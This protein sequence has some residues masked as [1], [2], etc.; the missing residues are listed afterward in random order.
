[1][2]V[3]VRTARHDELDAVAALTERGF[4]AGP[5][6]PTTDPDRLR[7]LRDAAGRAAAGDLLVAVRGRAAA[8]HA[9]PA[10]GRHGLH[11]PGAGRRGRGAAAHHRPRRARARRRRGARR[12]VDHPR[13]RL[14]R[15]GA[16]ARHRTAQR[17]VA[18]AVPPPGVRAGGRARDRRRAPGCGPPGRV[19]LR[20][21]PHRPAGAARR[22]A[23]ARP[24]RAAVRRRLRARLRPSRRL[25]RLAGGRRDPST[26]AR[27]VGRRGPRHGRAARHRRDP[28]TRRA[29]LRARS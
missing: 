5:Y 19:P 27:G 14:G 16:G 13:A 25:P 24:G 7:L 28:P 6:G 8:R 26:G 29:H 18:A 12:R 3:E 23:R 4:G 9:Q 20:P 17:G 1:M 10:A 15:A 21:R 22:A 2:S 11:A